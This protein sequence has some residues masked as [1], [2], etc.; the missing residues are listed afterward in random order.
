[1]ELP[2]HYDFKTAEAKWTKYWEEKGIYRFNPASNKPIYAIDTP[3]PTV[4]GRMHIG[5]A[6]SYSQADF[7][8]RYRRMRGYN[9]FYPFG[10]D[11]NGLP[12][13]RLVES[14]NKV[15]ATEMDR[16]EFIQLCLN[17]LEKIRPQFV[18]DW[19]DIGVSADFSI[20]YSTI[21]EHCRRI[22]QES[23]IELYEKGREYRKESPIMWCPECQT[24]IAQVEAEDKELPSFFNDI[25]FYGEN[26]EELI[27]STTRPEFLPATV[28]LFCHPDDERYKHLVGKKA[29]VPLF[30]YEVPIL[31]DESV[32]PEKGTGLMMVCTF[33]DQ[34]DVEKW[35]KYQLPL[36]DLLTKDGKLKEIAGKY[37]GYG[38]HV[39]RK[40][41]IEDLKD[42]RL[43]ISQ[44]P[45]KHAV[46]VHERCGTEIEFI[47]SKQWFI[48][49]L[50][51]K[52]EFL[53][54]GRAL[55]WYPQHMFSRLENWIKGL[56]WDWCI[57]RQRF[58][59]VPFPVWYCKSCEEPI[60]ADK[61]DL[62]VD[63]IKDK[64]PVDKCPKCG[65]S[66]FIPE[67]DVLDTW[68]TSSLTPQIAARLFPEKY[69]KIYPMTLR[70]Q[71]HDIITFW[72]FN[73]L[74][75][76]QLHNKV[77][78]WKDVMISGFVL[79]PHGK[80]MSKS[81]GNVVAPQDVVE[82]Y[83][84]DCLRFWA[85]GSKLGDDLPYQEKDLVTG[86]KFITKLWNASRFVIMNLK[87]YNGKKPARLE[88][89]DK[90]ILSKMHTLIKEC[91]DSFES[92]DYSKTKSATEKFF[93]QMICDNYLEIVKD[94]IYNPDK[95]T[96]EAV[97]SAQYTLYQL[98][99]TTIKLMAPIT[100]YITEEIYHLYFKEIE[101][102][103]S[104]HVSEWPIVDEEL[105]NANL[106][107]MGEVMLYVI[108]AVR[109][110]KSE[111]S[112]SLKEPLEKVTIIAD[113]NKELFTEIEKDLK[114]VTKAK[115]IDYTYDKE[116]KEIICEIIK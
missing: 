112:L 114:G 56:K 23:F 35:I 26:G 61:K 5:H 88:T 79:D 6:S 15:K 63:P 96:K 93:W 87:D 105:L 34:E 25:I 66:E 72:L 14:M 42:E 57:S 11:D 38:I 109:R 81:K 36:K 21:N 10:T 53:K 103:E 116:S 45:I 52:E 39:A 69:D 95:Y 4:S 111:Q 85:A 30:N 110:F 44:T 115:E 1:M 24:A 54:A 108:E 27:I 94:R 19:K 68:A 41:I 18:Q 82:K 76:S 90:W 100:P 65:S 48:K 50:D 99:L 80:K 101:G 70:P 2:K 7:V 47:N 67:T 64:P 29:K 75:K 71:A 17:T 22:S 43:L 92:Y 40:M 62:P 107:R 74:V 3:P 83:G 86:R 33:G 37:T 58:F 98:I 78:P 20:F 104:I 60:I 106:D 28:A 59:G 91:T 55:N 102:N 9:M 84:A 46:K 113:L 16:Q 73:T 89:V 8:A 13:E 31:T 97:E 32:D 77:N 12:T 51:L 49:Y